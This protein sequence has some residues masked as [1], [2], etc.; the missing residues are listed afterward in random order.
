MKVIL[1]ECVVDD[2]TLSPLVQVLLPW[3]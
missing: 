1:G 3:G 2:L